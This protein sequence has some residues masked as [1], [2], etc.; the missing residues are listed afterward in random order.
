MNPWLIFGAYVLIM[1]VAYFLLRKDGED[2]IGAVARAV[3]WPWT[4]A[5]L[6]I[7]IFVAGIPEAIYHYVYGRHD[8][9]AH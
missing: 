8:Q 4:V 5:A 1:Y 2:P 9:D 3:F 6:L 7:F